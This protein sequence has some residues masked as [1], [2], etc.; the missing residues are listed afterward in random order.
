MS[1]SFVKFKTENNTY[2]ISEVE[3]IYS[4]NP[5]LR[6]VWRMR[7]YFHFK[8]NRENYPIMYLDFH[9]FFMFLKKSDK[10]LLLTKEGENSSFTNILISNAYVFQNTLCVC[11][12][13]ESMERTANIITSEIQEEIN[14]EVFGQLS[15]KYPD[16][17]KPCQFTKDMEILLKIG[18]WDMLNEYY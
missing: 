7:R 8:G 2:V 10:V 14:P 4:S 15:I 17:L 16:M 11:G 18:G 12:I 9:N 1:N 6:N 5:I 3:N 13:S